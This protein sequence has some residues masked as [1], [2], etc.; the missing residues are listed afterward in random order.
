ME[1]RIEYKIYKAQIINQLKNCE[2]NGYDG[3]IDKLKG[4]PLA[5]KKEKKPFNPNDKDSV[6]KSQADRTLKLEAKKIESLN[7]N[8]IKVD[9]YKNL[10]GSIPNPLIV[11]FKIDYTPTKLTSLKTR[12][13][14]QDFL[15][16]LKIFSLPLLISL[17]STS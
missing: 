7:S 9:F 6:I 11:F 10:S 12:K 5:M 8:S 1:F 16:R 15:I 14:K 2:E 13:R 17:I 3:L 4:R